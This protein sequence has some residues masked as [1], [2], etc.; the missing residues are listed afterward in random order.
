MVFCRSFATHH[1]VAIGNCTFVKFIGTATIRSIEFNYDEICG[2][3]GTF[4][5]PKAHTHTHTHCTTETSAKDN[6]CI[7]TKY[8]AVTVATYSLLNQNE[9]ALPFWISHRRKGKLW[10][11][12]FSIR[13]HFQHILLH[14]KLRI[15]APYIHSPFAFL[16]L[17]GRQKYVC[18]IPAKTL[19]ARKEWMIGQSRCGHVK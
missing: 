19:K 12:A 14:L 11:S 4:K 7:I 2:Q 5:A 13:L 3:Q 9:L 8:C 16:L 15:L 10:Y 1:V 17:R 18:M 6:R